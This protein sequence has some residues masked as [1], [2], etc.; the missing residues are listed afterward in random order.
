MDFFAHL[1]DSWLWFLYYWSRSKETRRNPATALINVKIIH[2]FW[3]L[4]CFVIRENR[5]KSQDRLEKDVSNS[6]E[7]KI[8]LKLAP[9][10]TLRIGTINWKFASHKT[11]KC[12]GLYFLVDSQDGL[13]YLGRIT[14]CCSM[15]I[16]SRTGGVVFCTLSLHAEG[17]WFKSSQVVHMELEWGR[18]ST[19][20]GAYWFF[21]IARL[22]LWSHIW[23]W[24]RGEVSLLTLIS[25]F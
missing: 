14:E 22:H 2:S 4:R 24:S 10:S 9:T 13:N 25:L 11:P 6:L 20:G 17:P 19:F 12:T 8:K 23:I 15:R 7:I 21:I 3:V 16:V 1:I 18:D 5:K